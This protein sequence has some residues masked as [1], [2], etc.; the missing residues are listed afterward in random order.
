M[1]A[2]TIFHIVTHDIL[3]KELHGRCDE[4]H[5]INNYHIFVQ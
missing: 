2:M 4:L 5:N 1:T 3:H